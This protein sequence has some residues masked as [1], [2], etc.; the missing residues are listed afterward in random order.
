MVSTELAAALEALHGTPQPIEQA[1]VVDVPEP[2][3]ELS[4]VGCAR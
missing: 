4:V 1:G 3:R 2:Q